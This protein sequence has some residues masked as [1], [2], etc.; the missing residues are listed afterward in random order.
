MTV[1][2]SDGAHTAKISTRSR[3][4]GI[5]IISVAY[6]SFS[7]I[8]FGLAGTSHSSAVDG[9]RIRRGPGK[10]I[11]VLHLAA[12]RNHNRL[13]SSQAAARARP[14]LSLK[15]SNVYVHP[16]AGVR[17]CTVHPSTH[18]YQHLRLAQRLLATQ[19]HHLRYQSY[20]KLF[21]LMAA[22]SRFTA[23]SPAFQAAGKRTW[24]ASGLLLPVAKHRSLRA[25]ERFCLAKCA[26]HF[27][28]AVISQRSYLR[29]LCILRVI[30]DILSTPDRRRQLRCHHA[31]TGL[32]PRLRSDQT[33]AAIMRSVANLRFARLLAVRTLS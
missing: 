5:D 30:F 24:Y 32:Q 22:P 15:L 31:D 29:S 7:T 17:I 16:L 33:T 8:M 12:C 14:A 23:S 4:V 20:V 13:E 3:A 28:I 11:A 26:A 6:K 25:R 9:R 1:R 2:G 27:I 10:E 21:A 19:R 18:Y